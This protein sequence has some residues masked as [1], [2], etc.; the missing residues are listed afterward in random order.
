MEAYF[1]LLEHQDVLINTFYKDSFKRLSKIFLENNNMTT[2]KSLNP[3]VYIT[4][5]GGYNPTWQGNLKIR[6]NKLYFIKSKNSH[7][8]TLS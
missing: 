5:R 7:I 8:Y 2:R 4:S 3:E 6:T 1:Y